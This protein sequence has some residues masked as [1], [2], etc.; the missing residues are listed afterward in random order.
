MRDEVDQIHIYRS[1]FDWVFDEIFSY[2]IYV[3]S[4]WHV[5]YLFNLARFFSYIDTLTIYNSKIATLSE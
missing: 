4:P 1:Y 2:L 5:G 3:N